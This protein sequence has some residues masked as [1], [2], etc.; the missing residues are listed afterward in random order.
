MTSSPDRNDGA[1][2]RWASDPYPDYAP[3]VNQSINFSGLDQSFFTRGKADKVIEKVKSLGLGR[4]ARLLDIGCGPGLIHGFLPPSVCEVSGVDVSPTPLD[5]ARQRHPGND[6]QLYDGRTLPFA[7]ASFDLAVTV[8]VVHHVAVA[9]WV[10]FLEEALRVLRPGG[11]LV[12]CEHNPWNPLTRL[13]VHRCAF[14]HDAVL[15]SAPTARALLAQAG[16]A[17][18][19]I[20]YIFFTPFE[21]AAVRKIE[22]AIRRLPLGAQ[23]VATARRP[24][25]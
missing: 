7:D 18:P 21:N 24:V 20:E 4:P 1:A 14:D 22:H 15:L 11:A 25:A 23:Y 17:P 13:A 5:I 16:F 8:C 19:E 3:E 6:Y 10:G 9:E 12:I 2:S